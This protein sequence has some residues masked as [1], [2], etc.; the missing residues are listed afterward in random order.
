MRILT[1]NYGSTNLKWAVF[2]DDVRSEAGRCEATDDAQLQAAVQEILRSR[3]G[4][5][6]PNAVDAPSTRTSAPAAYSPKA[7]PADELP[8]TPQPPDAVVHRVVHGG[9][10]ERPAVID[11]AVLQEITRATAFSPIHN[12][13]ALIGIHAAERFGVPQIAVFDTAFHAT[14]PDVARTYALPRELRD[15]GI[16]RFGFHGLA[17]SSTLQQTA[18][19]LGTAAAD[20]NAILVHLGGGCSVRAVEGGRSIDTSMGLT[21]LEGL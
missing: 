21:P 3:L 20:I 5:S 10:L 19:V 11:A 13:R 4:R 17:F 18:D 15:R 14:L 8:A 1:L 9:R 7:F 16:R 2:E 6:G 12:R